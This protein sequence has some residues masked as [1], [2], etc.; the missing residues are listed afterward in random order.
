MH[1]GGG[2]PPGESESRN[3]RRGGREPRRRP[4]LVA[5]APAPAPGRD[6]RVGGVI[7]EHDGVGGVFAA[8]ADPTRR[9][10]VARLADGGSATAT[11]LAGT[12]LIS[13]QAVCKHLDQLA[14]AGLVSAARHGREMRYTL[15]PAALADAAAWMARVGGRWDAR[16][17]ALTRHVEAGRRRGGG[18]TSAGRAGRRP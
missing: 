12:L 10:V 13:R 2:G 6:P 9:H 7:P 3:S 8:L 17:A 15:S 16:L 14:E 1:Q 11:E 18:A 5:S 4:G